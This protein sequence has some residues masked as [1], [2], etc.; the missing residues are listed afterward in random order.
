M[1][2]CPGD[3]CEHYS[4]A[5]KY[6][7]KC[8]YEPQCWRGIVDSFFTMYEVIKEGKNEKRMRNS[9]SKE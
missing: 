5:T 2:L 7:R 4:K 3:K 6:P 8:Y 1:K 9:P